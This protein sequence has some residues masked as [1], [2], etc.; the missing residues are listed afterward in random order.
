MERC[1]F[2]IMFEGMNIHPFIASSSYN[3]WRGSFVFQM[4]RRVNQIVITDSQRENA[5][6]TD[7]FLTSRNNNIIVLLVGSVITLCI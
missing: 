6:R 1:G 2:E 5:S 7:K 3:F 4:Y